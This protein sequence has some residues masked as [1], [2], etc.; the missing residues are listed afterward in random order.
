M[1]IVRWIVITALAVGFLLMSVAN[2]TPVA[3]HW[4]D[5][6]VSTAR[7]PLLLGAAFV[8]GW[9]PTWLVHVGVRAGWKRKLARAERPTLDPTTDTKGQLPSQ[10]QPIV[11]PPAGA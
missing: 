10:A 8:A 4:P 2:W 6:S 5:G 11:V 9:L 1:A 3:F 7:L